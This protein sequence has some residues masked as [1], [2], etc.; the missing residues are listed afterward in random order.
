MSLASPPL[1]RL[2]STEASHLT[3]ESAQ[4]DVAHLFVLEQDIIRV[5]VL[6]GGRLEMGRTWAIAPGQDDVPPQGR[7]RFDL[8]GFSLPAFTQSVDDANLTIETE[9]IRLT[10]R[11]AGLFCIWDIKT[12]GVW[13]RAARDRQT[14]AYDFGYW[15]GGPRHYLRR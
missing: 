5:M 3:L 8:N 10:I 6:P 1:F 14:Q 12:G 9:A 15:D 11:L 4:G 2:A 7:D 13:R